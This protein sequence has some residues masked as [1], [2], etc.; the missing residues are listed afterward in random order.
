MPVVAPMEIV[1]DPLWISYHRMSR[2]GGYRLF[3]KHAQRKTTIK[4]HLG[5]NQK[6]K[7]KHNKT[8]RATKQTHK[9]EKDS[10]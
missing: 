1:N 2:G 7:R 9:Q 5:N 10:K 4:T 6:P 3:G 8:T